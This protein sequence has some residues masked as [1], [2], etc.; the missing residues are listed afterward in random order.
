M[1]AKRKVTIYDLAVATG[2]SPTAVSLVLND[3]WRRYRIR[4]ETALRIIQAAERLGYSVNLKA[5][6]L[7]LSKSGLA[8]MIMPHYRNRFF[9]GLAE[10][11]GTEARAR[12]LCPIVVT[13]QRNPVNER[14][15]SETLLSQ[16][17]E[18]LFFAGVHNPEPLNELCR[19]VG[20]RCVN[21]DLPGSLAPSV[22]S[23]NRMGARQLT[24]ALLGRVAAMGRDVED[25]TFVGGA[26]EDAATRSRLL[27]FRDAIAEAGLDAERYVVDCCGYPPTRAA[28]SIAEQYRRNGR[29]PAGLFMNGVTA[30]EGVLRFTA[31][32]PRDEV[33]SLV[34]GSFDWD[35]FGAHLH[36]DLT[37]VRQNVEALIASGFE[38]IDAYKHN[39]RRQPL[40]VVPTI[41]GGA[42]QLDGVQE[43]WDGSEPE[44]LP[45]AADPPRPPLAGPSS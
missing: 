10:A 37:M 33:K 35:P 7:R 26:A 1:P 43:D 31:T 28:A 2:A 45:P 22:V 9:A 17:V 38:L 29:L 19:S 3:S 15:A 8:G 30:L 18:F 36:F 4:E 6:G 14:R 27:G 23:D 5:R 34:A 12:N 20:V 32:L 39:R 21:I 44:T 40:V 16:Q 24:T 42:G 13:T 41:I 11:F 25:I